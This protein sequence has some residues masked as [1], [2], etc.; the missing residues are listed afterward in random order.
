MNHDVNYPSMAI[1]F[2]IQSTTYLLGAI[3]FE[4]LK[5]NYLV[6]NGYAVT[7]ENLVYPPHLFLIG[8]KQVLLRNDTNSKDFQAQ[9][10]LTFSH[11]GFLR[12]TISLA[13][14]IEDYSTIG[15]D[16]F[17][18]KDSNFV[19][20][21]VSLQEM[22][23]KLT[24]PIFGKSSF[25]IYIDANLKSD[26]IMDYCKKYG[27]TLSGYDKNVNISAIVSISD[28][29]NWNKV[30]EIELQKTAGGSSLKNTVLIPNFTTTLV[31][32]N[33][34]IHFL[35]TFNE[36]IYTNEQ[37]ID[38]TFNLINGIRYQVSGL[39]FL[40]TNIG[41]LKMDFMQLKAYYTNHLSDNLSWVYID[42]TL[43][44]LENRFEDLISTFELEFLEANEPTYVNFQNFTFKD[45]L[46]DLLK[47][48]STKSQYF[49]IKN[50][51][52]EVLTS[53]RAKV[54]DKGEK[55]EKMAYNRIV[56]V[57]G[58]L[59]SFQV[60]SEILP[61][62]SKNIVTV[63]RVVF[64]F[65]LLPLLLVIW[66]ITSYNNQKKI[67]IAEKLQYKSKIGKQKQILEMS[68]QYFKESSNLEMLE[69]SKTE[70]HTIVTLL[71]EKIKEIAIQLSKIEENGL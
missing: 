2:A 16:L 42:K 54:S 8:K 4:L 70:L 12:T 29:E 38:H 53:L 44:T 46:N 41:S 17:S 6:L 43:T 5:K 39:L 31:S 32:N 19:M 22:S 37:I 9:F 52:Q 35:L 3:D 11:N 13:I 1:T 47:Y 64:I 62:F 30:K 25:E 55:E 65:A 33:P 58:F 69:L 48:N 45:R 57:I 66:Y 28:E 34:D 40:I 61:L 67:K 7:E 27:I 68:L 23:Y 51:F 56:A 15:L 50:H 36:I 20:N 71:Q 10:D 63:I 24:E 21:S 14:D 26:Y 59:A 60:V 18:S 49:I